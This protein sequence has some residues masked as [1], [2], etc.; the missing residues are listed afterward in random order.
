MIVHITNIQRAALNSDGTH[1]SVSKLK[2]AITY[3]AVIYRN[4]EELVPGQPDIT[5]YGYNG[6]RWLAGPRAEL[7]AALFA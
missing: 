2:G 7:E 1:E 3:N 5:H 6:K 4:N